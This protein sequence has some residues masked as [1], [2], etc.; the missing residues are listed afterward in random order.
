MPS[1]ICCPAC[2]RVLQLPGDALNCMVQ[3]PACKHQFHPAEAAPAE[4][5]R[6]ASFKSDSDPAQTE[7]AAERQGPLPSSR[8][9]PASRSPERVPLPPEFEPRT[10]DR[11]SKRSVQD[12][13]PKCQAS[14]PVGVNTCPECGAEFEPEEDSEYR[15]WEQAGLERRD[16]ES[17]RGGFLLTM[18]IVSLFTPIPFFC[19]YV[20]IATSFLGLIL[21]A[22]TVWLG[23]NDL[24]KMRQ[25]VMIREGESITKSACTCGVIG[26]VLN[27]LGL[28]ASVA[29]VLFAR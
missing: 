10:I 20:G 4:S 25:R 5:I 27:L 12:L 19:C 11:R 9:E 2:K 6:P 28:A 1:A 7:S 15:P 13:C 26:I 18:G 3:C 21:A 29:I 8:S 22:T 14:V 16:S 17:H 23:R 24:Q